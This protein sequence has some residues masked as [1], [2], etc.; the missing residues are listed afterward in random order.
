MADYMIVTEGLTATES[1]EAVEN[2]SDYFEAVVRRVAADAETGDRVFVSPGNSFG[3][4]KSEEDYAAEFLQKLRPDLQIF[5]P[6]NVR[7]RTYLDTFDNARVLRIG[8]Q[9]EK[10]WPLGDVILYCNQPH[11]RRSRA[12]FQFCGFRVERVVGCR[13]ETVSR[14]IAPRLWFYNYPPVQFLYESATLVYD[15]CRFIVWKVS[16][17]Q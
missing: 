6:A 16:G 15:S 8:L 14:E 5:V 13:P 10:L 9:R 17:S 1:P 12:M 3:H 2:L 11:S 4:S 7:D